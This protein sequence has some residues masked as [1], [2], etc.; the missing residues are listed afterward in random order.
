MTDVTRRTVVTGAGVAAAAALGAAPAGAKERRIG[1]AAEPEEAVAVIG[2]I[3]QEGVHMTGYGWV[4]HVTGID[5]DALFTDPG[6]RG[7]GT[8]RLTWTAD[9]RVTA[10]DTL[11]EVFSAAA[12]GRLSIHYNARGGADGDKPE[13]FSAGRRVAEYDAHFRNVLTVTSPDRA[14]TEITADLHQRSSA[15]FRIAG[16]ERRLGRTGLE[17]RM[18]ASGRG[19]RLEPTIPRATFNVAGSLVIPS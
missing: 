9:A 16:R 4:T 17:Q 14:V 6:A 18:T 5:D 13:T 3:V 10:R 11:P 19:I 12:T 7:A 1:V 2:T 8:A 15:R